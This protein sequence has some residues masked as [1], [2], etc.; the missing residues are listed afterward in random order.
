MTDPWSV[1]SEHQQ[2]VARPWLAERERERHHV[3]I[4]LSGAHAYGFPSPDSDLDLKCVHLVPTA[5]L[6]GLRLVDDPPDK[7]VIVDGVELD[8]SSNELATALRAI[9]KGNG[10]YLE[11]ILGDLQLG[12]RDLLDEARVVVRPLISRRVA[13]HYGGFAK[14]QLKAF[15]EKPTAKR[16][17]YV[18]RTAATGRCLMARGELVTE[19]ARLGDFVPAEIEEL[20]VI[21]RVGE[22]QQL[23][24][25]HAAAWRGKL[26]AA[27]A[28]VHAAVA[29]SVLPAE[30]PDE[31]L[32]AVERWLRDVRKRSW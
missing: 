29:S 25:D 13:H 11:R 19:V 5:E 22:R 1:L 26:V 12:D 23:E 14:S 8:Y 4:Y 3:A 32:A 20:L 30:P 6:V 18:L 28:A 9:I 17:L 15:D 10:N 2:Q 16:A 21:K 24:A 31:A 7:I 27:I